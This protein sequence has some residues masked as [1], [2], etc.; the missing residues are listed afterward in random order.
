[1]LLNVERARAVMEH[2]GLDG[3]VAST[4]ENIFYLSGM[5]QL[6][7][8]LFPYDDQCYVVANHE[9][10]DGGVVVSSMGD[11]D[12]TL[13]AYPSIGGVITYSSF[14]RELAPGVAALQ[15]ALDAAALAAPG[16]QGIAR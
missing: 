10:P 12:L 7:V 16:P 14:F 3:L 2:E 1:M 13:Q 5:W 6:G 11:A 9:R 15:P 8:E 4:L